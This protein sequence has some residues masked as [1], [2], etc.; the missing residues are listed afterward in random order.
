MKVPT[1]IEL[2][3]CVCIYN[4]SD[5]KHSRLVAKTLRQFSESPFKH[6]H[7]PDILLPGCVFFFFFFGME[8]GVVSALADVPVAIIK[9][10]YAS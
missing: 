4:L 7:K 2:Q 8:V 1:K 9:E 3:G 6:L 10:I 5:L